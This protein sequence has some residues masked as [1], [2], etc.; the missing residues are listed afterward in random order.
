VGE[1]GSALPS[2]VCAPF[3]CS[4]PTFSQPAGATADKVAADVASARCSRICRLRQ[5][6]AP[7]SK[8][9][10]ESAG[11]DRAGRRASRALKGVLSCPPDMITRNRICR[12]QQCS[13]F[14]IAKLII[15]LLKKLKKV[16]YKKKFAFI[17]AAL[18]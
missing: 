12:I 5:V 10:V 2:G 13:T 1:W 18:K 17:M 3:F 7:A 14:V 11:F 16:Q 8:G 6:Q 15:L 4:Q 9:A